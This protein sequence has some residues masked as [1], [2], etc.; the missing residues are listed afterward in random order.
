[1]W[2]R[3]IIL[4]CLL[5][6]LA[7][8]EDPL[9]VYYY[10]GETIEQLTVRGVTVTISLDDTGKFNQ[11]AVF[12]S[13]SSSDAVNVLPSSFTLH[14]TDPKEADLV[15]MSEQEIQR[16]AGKHALWTHVASG[17]TSSVTYMK[18]KMSGEE[19]QSSQAAV[20]DYDAQARWLAHVDELGKRGQTGT[21]ARSYLRGTTL[22]PGSR[23]S[24]VLWFDRIDVFASGMLRV[25]LGSRTYSF[26]L[27]PPA[28]A[29]TPSNPG[30]IEKSSQRAP[31]QAETTGTDTTEADPKPGVLGVYG[32]NWSQDSFGGVR[33]VEIMDNSAADLA[34]LRVGYVITEIDGKR[35]LSTNDLNTE[36]AKRSPGTR[37]TIVYLVHTNLGWMPQ[38]ASAILAIGE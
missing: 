35:I 9:H 6:G 36:L 23:L 29:T 28:W 31:A 10:N 14:Q 33:I 5:T 16:I 12:V 25:A 30:K 13:N 17:V 4:L 2:C 20:Q 26:P 11:V 18:E 22:F 37:I 24:G 38:K 19:G 8:A 1:M 7:F 34:G 3:L 32:E 27:P 15:L 21:L